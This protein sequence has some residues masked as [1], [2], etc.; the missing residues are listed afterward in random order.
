MLKS[1]GGKLVN[2]K[3]INFELIKWLKEHNNIESI[4]Y[5]VVNFETELIPA[6]CSSDQRERV[7]HSKEVI[8]KIWYFHEQL[9]PYPFLDTL[10]QFEFDRVYYTDY[11][12]HSSHQLKVYL[13]GLYLFEKSS[14]VKKNI[15]NEINLKDENI[16]TKEFHLRWFITAVYH[17]I[18]YVIENE[19]TDKKTNEV[20]EKTKSTLNNALHAPLSYLTKFEKLLSKEKE[21]Q[22][23]QN[24]SIF[25]PTVTYPVSIERD[26]TCDDFLNLIGECSI[27]ANLGTIQDNVKS[28]LRSYYDFATKTIPNDGRPKFKD[29]GIASS[30][31]LLKVW[32]SFRDY[33]FKLS[34]IDKEVLLSQSQPSIISL[35]KLLEKTESTV[36]AAASAISLHNINKDIWEK[37]E[38]LINHLTLDDFLLRIEPE[39]GKKATPLA[40]LLGIVD[41]IQCW[42]RPMFSTPSINNRHITDSDINMSSYNDKIY[43]SFNDDKSRFKKNPKD[44]TD[45]LFSRLLFGIGR[46][47]DIHSV[48]KILDCPGNCKPSN[49][50]NENFSRK[51]STSVSA[52]MQ[53]L[54]KNNNEDISE[55]FKLINS[56]KNW[57]VGA[58]NFDEDLHFSSFYLYQSWKHKLPDELK[59]FGYKNIIACYKDFNEIYFIPEQECK[60]VAD[61]L[62]EKIKENPFWFNDILEKIKKFAE[63]LWNVFPFE[64]DSRPFKNMSDFELIKYYTSHN[65]EHTRLY[66]YSRLPEALD[67]GNNYF[68]NH[69]KSYLEGINS[70]FTNAKKLN[71]VFE[72]F[73][74]PEDLSISGNEFTEFVKILDKIKND[75]EL[76]ELIGNQ[77]RDIFLKADPDF[78]KEIT[79]HREKWTFWGYH[80]YRTRALRDIN[81]FLKKLKYSV[82]D[83]SLHEKAINFQHAFD[84]AKKR[85]KEY[86]EKYSIDSLYQMLFRLYSRIGTTKLYR[87]YIQL[88]NFYFLDLLISKISE[89]FNVKE[90]IIR[91]LLPEEVEQLLR[92]ELTV[93]KEHKE[94]VLNST[95]ILFENEQR[96]ITGDEA[97]KIR[98]RLKSLTEKDNYVSETLTGQPLVTSSEIIKGHCRIILRTEDLE[99]VVLNY[100]DILV[101]ESADPDYFDLMQTAGAVLT[102][103]GGVTAHAST[104]C[105]E[106]K[107]ISVIGV[108][109]LLKNIFN[110]DLVEIDTK[111]G[112]IRKKTKISDRLIVTPKSQNINNSLIGN[113]AF[114]LIN[115]KNKGLN[116][117]D[118]FCIPLDSLRPLLHRGTQDNIGFQSQALWDDVNSELNC[119]HGELFAI[120]SSYNNE[121]TPNSSCAGLYKSELYVVKEDIIEIIISTASD[122]FFSKDTN[123]SGSLIVQEMILGDFSGVLFTKNPLSNADE[124]LLE[125]IPGGNELLTDNKITPSQYLID[126][127]NLEIKEI[128]RDTIVKHLLK[129]TII[130]EISETALNIEN[131]FLKPQDIEW[132]ITDDLLYILQ[133]RPITKNQGERKADH[134]QKSAKQNNIIS[135]YRSYRVPLYIQNHMLQVAGIGQWIIDNWKGEKLNRNNVITTLLLHDILNLIRNP[136]PN[137]ENTFPDIYNTVSGSS[138]FVGHWVAVQQRLKEK[139]GNFDVQAVISVA[140]E[141]GVNERVIYLLENK[142]FVNNEFT[143]ESND[144]E[145]KICSYSDQR[146]SPYGI[147]PIRKRLNEAVYRYRGIKSASVNNP[148]RELL[149]DKAEEIEKQIFKF[150]QK[151]PDEINDNSIA[152][153]LKMLRNYHL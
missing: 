6:I 83:N 22:I 133:S 14:I 3:G 108:N 91:N 55:I 33:V 113:K 85:K 41:S 146:V 4:L 46:Y 38:A 16:A 130:K 151:N 62:I 9:G 58:V 116:V 115:L 44:E 134:F 82:D 95:L 60:R 36:Y 100:G 23:I 34:K 59:E 2:R 68:T 65:I 47:L 153:Y 28:P 31:L 57:L 75:S 66:Q 131:I 12:D 72:I 93:T 89:N 120:R 96:L 84:E 137:L 71:E 87:R 26:E 25:N 111:Q 86:F 106:N 77:S 29:H 37:Q 102:E 117:P 53:S 50:I 74:F 97:D 54:D 81:Y 70:E 132:T 11:R 19:Q 24:N 10:S 139:Y 78:L 119:L 101:L 32:R 90:E 49:R 103:Q 80:G 63:N 121:D 52:E 112:T 56:Y 140:K 5:N 45:S 79:Q 39:N 51:I 109:G 15:L 147:L 30:L 20:W 94:R 138:K 152:P 76:K 92:Y 67:R 104:F 126:R 144:F 110:N 40:F 143:L 142:Q 122:L 8:K 64:A 88:R 73:T 18:G 48:N 148:K 13:L 107:I 114:N 17:D 135:I 118:F 99:K 129:D 125:A 43:I 128:S 21:E 123:V 27:N 98:M 149:I 141:L 1:K 42:D 150:I 127:K 136:F 105:R 61:A 35:K 69:L 145:L 7:A 124:I